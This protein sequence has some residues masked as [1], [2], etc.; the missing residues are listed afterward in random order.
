MDAHTK[1]LIED[2]RDQLRLAHA[3]H[4]ANKP[5]IQ[6]VRNAERMLGL[7]LARPSQPIAV[8]LDAIGGRRS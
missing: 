6:H 8:M 2:A 1:S 3:A 5:S 4:E 7:L